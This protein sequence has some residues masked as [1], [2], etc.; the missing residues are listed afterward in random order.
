LHKAPQ[1]DVG[2]CNAVPGLEVGAARSNSGDLAGE[3][4]RGVAGEGLGVERTRSRCSLAARQ[5]R[6]AG[7]AEAG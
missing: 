1:K 4:G 6:Q 2:P 5:G 3:L 7:T